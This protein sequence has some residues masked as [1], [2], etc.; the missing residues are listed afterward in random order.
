MSERGYTKEGKV[1][2][3]CWNDDGNFSLPF[4]CLS[5]FF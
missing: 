4:S 2:I 1:V 5:V 3:F